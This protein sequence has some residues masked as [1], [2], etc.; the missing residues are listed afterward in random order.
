MCCDFFACD[1]RMQCPEGCSCFHDSVW[2]ANIIECSARNHTDVPLLIPMDATQVRLDGNNLKN[3]DTQSFIGRRRVTSLFMNASSVTKIS[4]QTFNG[5]ANLEV[6]HLEDNQ[7]REI[8]GHEFESLSALTELYLQNNDLMHIKDTAF[9]LL[10]SLTLLRLD[11][12]LL[13][14]FPAWDLVGSHRHPFLV[15]LHLSNN[16]WSC[17]CE[18]LTPFARFLRTQG[19]DL[20][21]A[22]IVTHVVGRRIPDA[23]KV[24]CISDNLVSDPIVLDRGHLLTH[25]TPGGEN[26]ALLQSGETIISTKPDLVAILVGTAVALLVVVF[27]FLAVCIFRAKIKTWLYNK[28]SEIY[29]SRSGSSVHSAAYSTYAQNKLFYI[30]I[31]ITA[32]PRQA[33]QT[34]FPISQWFVPRFLHILAPNAP[35]HPVS[36]SS[37]LPLECLRL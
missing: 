21:D 25:C 19:E 9:S 27:A 1:C 2:S 7:I 5:L 16:L 15:E 37:S 33:Y 34:T 24:T 29:E 17:E 32:K 28:S 3:V 11:G 6:L 14:T 18:F 22:N 26:K 8:V 23:D 30:I 12:N 36:V 20:L 10:T 13:T 4:P 31:I 35:K